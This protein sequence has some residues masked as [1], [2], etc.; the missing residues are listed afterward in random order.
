VIHGEPS[1]LDNTTSCFGGAVRLNRS[2]GR[3]E[4]LPHLP[5]MNILLTNTKSPRKT[6]LLVKAV[7]ELNE[8]LPLCVKPIFD[9]V[10]AIS[11]EFLQMIDWSVL[12]LTCTDRVPVLLTAP[13]PSL[14]TMKRRRRVDQRSVKRNS[15][16][17]W[18]ASLALPSLPSL[19]HGIPRNGSSR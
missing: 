6:K 7:R 3:F 1:G 12:R 9:S 18:C 13:L 4:T 14:V 5:T 15:L 2:L 10:E 16:R 17:L 8:A 19:A 11:Q